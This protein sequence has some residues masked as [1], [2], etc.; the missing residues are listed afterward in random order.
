MYGDRDDPYVAL[1]RLGKRLEST[2]A[3]G[4]VLPGI[5]ETVAQTLKLPYA[6]ILLR[7]E[8]DFVTVAEYGNPPEEPVV[9]P[10]T[11]GT[12]TV[13]RFVLG[14]RAPGNRSRPRTCACSKTWPGRWASPPTRCALRRTCNARAS[15]S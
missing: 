13:G 3:P 14:P 6:A 7:Q 2:L 9:L 5:V 11:Y 12:E 1:S 4:A 10:L 15:A 8:D